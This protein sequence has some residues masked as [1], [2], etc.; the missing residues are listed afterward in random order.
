MA[1][2][3]LQLTQTA[4]SAS[5]LSDVRRDALEETIRDVR[6]YAR[7]AVTAEERV[8]YSE[9]EH[10]LL[11]LRRQWEEAGLISSQ[12]ELPLAAEAPSRR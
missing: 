11:E 5:K 3:V 7:K 4:M 1:G 12:V 9:I 8:A 6:V 10:G 2:E